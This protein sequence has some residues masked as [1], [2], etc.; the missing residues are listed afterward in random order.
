MRSTRRPSSAEGMRRSHVSVDKSVYKQSNQDRRVAASWTRMVE[1][2]ATLRTLAKHWPLVSF[3]VLFRQHGEET[4]CH[5]KEGFKSICFDWIPH[6]TASTHV[7]M[8]AT[9][10]C[11]VH[12]L[13]LGG[14]HVR[15]IQ[16]SQFAT[17]V[18]AHSSYAC[19]SSTHPFQACTSPPPCT[20]IPTS[21]FHARA[22]DSNA[23]SGGGIASNHHAFVV[24]RWMGESSLPGVEH[25]VFASVDET[26]RDEKVAFRHGGRRRRWRS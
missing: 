20:S 11:C 25:V 4:R 18:H 21:C 9:N 23:R 14:V 8:H 10:K 24:E 12:I 5:P 17:T 19:L 15:S 22:A 13:G 2:G 6:G 1:R 7:M 3:L 26:K 16:P